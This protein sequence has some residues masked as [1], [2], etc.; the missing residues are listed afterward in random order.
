MDKRRQKSKICKGYP[1]SKHCKVVPLSLHPHSE[2]LVSEQSTP[3][4]MSTAGCRHTVAGAGL[5]LTPPGPPSPHLP[6]SLTQPAQEI[7]RI[8]IMLSWEKF[9]PF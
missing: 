2:G 3:T 9:I 8:D 1:Q 4:A 7:L 6:S 5:R